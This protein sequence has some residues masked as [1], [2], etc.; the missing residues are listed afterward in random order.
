MLHCF[1]KRGFEFG[2]SWIFALIVGAIILFLA[3]F[4]VTRMIETEKNVIDTEA[5]KK[6]GI[7]LTPMETGLESAKASKIEFVS[8][9]KFFN[10][11][12]NIGNFGVQEIRVA[13]KSGIGDAWEE[14]GI[15][16]SK[17]YNK[18]IFSKGVEQGEEM[19]V[20][21]KPFEFP[22]KVADLTY[23][24]SGKYCFVNPP[25]EMEE[26]LLAIEPMN[27]NISNFKDDCSDNDIVVCFE[28]IG[29]DIDVSLSGKSVKRDD[30][31]IYYDDRFGNALL[32][33]AIFADANVYECQVKRLM[34]R[35]SELSLLQATKSEYLSS[36]GCSSGLIAG[37][38]LFAE[39][40]RKIDDS[41]KLDMLS[42][43]AQQ[44]KV[45]NEN[46]ACKLF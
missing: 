31:I 23:V 34:K 19:T 22:F 29:C 25:G 11:C 46:L 13:S 37:L 40:A 32:Y 6:L 42:S 5:G 15:V 43:L 26:E 30:G 1:R 27:L 18:Y 35:T 4:A 21:V 41:S 28:S 12:K 10:Q 2:F 45:E 33:S 36:R 16:A 39:E 14:R 3:I 9:T 17:F 44:L 8:E 24:W 20:F 7:L 38:T